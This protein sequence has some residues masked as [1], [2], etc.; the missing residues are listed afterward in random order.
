MSIDSIEKKL[1]FALTGAILT[2]AINAAA[3]TP[4]QKQADKEYEVGAVLWQQSSGEHRALAYQAF[5][6]ARTVL[7]R[8]L[9]I[10]RRGKLRRAVV[11][12]VDE[13]IDRKSVV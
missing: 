10:N 12:D 3:Q 13:T 5:A 6:L 9:R 2:M 4:N 7:D 8:D 1:W 11:V